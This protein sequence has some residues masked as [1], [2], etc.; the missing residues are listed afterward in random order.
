[1]FYQCVKADTAA[2]YV[3]RILWRFR[4]ME[5]DPFIFATTQVH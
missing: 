3:R 4:D 1:M 2:Q 5:V